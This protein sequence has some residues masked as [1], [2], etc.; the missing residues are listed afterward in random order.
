[1]EALPSLLVPALIRGCL[2]CSAII[3]EHHR[4]VPVSNKGIRVLRACEVQGSQQL[5]IE[6]EY[7]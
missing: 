2:V 1:M 7:F 4:H 5:E 6:G 3:L